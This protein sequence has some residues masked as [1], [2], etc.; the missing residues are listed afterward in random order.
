[1]DFGT[2]DRNAGL[3]TANDSFYSRRSNFQKTE[4]RVLADFE[5]DVRRLYQDHSNRNNMEINFRMH[6]QKP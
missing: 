4:L 6:T 2:W 3:K 1:M 5:R